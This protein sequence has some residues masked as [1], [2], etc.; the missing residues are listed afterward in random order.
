MD[1]LRRSF[2]IVVAAASITPVATASA[3]SI[4]PGTHVRVW[5]WARHYDGYMER[6]DSATITVRVNGDPIVVRRSEV[7]S[8]E[9]ERRLTAVV[10]LS[11]GAVFA[12]IGAN[13]AQS[14]ANAYCSSD[15][16]GAD[17]RTTAVGAAV[18]GIPALVAGMLIG[19]RMVAWKDVPATVHVAPVDEYA[20]GRSR[21][22]GHR[23]MQITVKLR[24]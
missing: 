17:G 5:L 18:L 19:S 24:M 1:Q 20:A 21:G 2:A 8:I 3:Q 6:S 10:G 14:M 12:L 7:Q 22:V 13:T 9:R 11:A 15:C 4:D 23:A 16:P